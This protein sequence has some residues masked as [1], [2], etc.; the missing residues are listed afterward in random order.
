MNFFRKRVYATAGY[1]T[2][3]MGTGRKEFNPKKQRPGIEDYILEAGKG[4]LAQVA[5]PEAI[6][7]GVMVGIKTILADL[8]DAV[9]VVGAEVQNSVKAVYGADYLAGAGW[10]KQRKEGHAHFFPGQFSDRAGV[11]FEKFGKQKMREGMARWYVQAVENARLNP[12]AQEYHNAN[13][14]LYATAMTTPNPKVFCEHINVYDCSKVS[15]GAS[16]IIFASEE[17]LKKLGVNKKDTAEVVSYGQCEDDITNP[18]PDLTK[19]VT[20]QKAASIAYER[21]GLTP[22]DIGVLEVH[23]CFSIAGLLMVEAMGFAKYGEA[24]EFVAMGKTKRDGEIP[25]NTTGGLIGYGHPVGATGVRQS[26][27]LVQQLIG[28]GECQIS[29]DPNRPYGL[30]VSMGGND[31]TVVSMIFKKID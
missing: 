17:G 18:Q 7:E 16:A 3:S 15:D 31:I 9:L 6:D 19:M 14:D 27:D 26:A 21:A 13:E 20:S 23:D 22:K 30:M 11:C 8:A 12:K 4:T 1:Y 29:I 10:Y 25:T 24:A 2:I 5:N 28:K